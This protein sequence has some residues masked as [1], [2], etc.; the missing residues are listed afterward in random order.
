[1]PN[2]LGFIFGISQMI[3]Y[4]VYRGRKLPKIIE[5]GRNNVVEISTI[6]TNAA[7]LLN[8]A[9]LKEILPDVQIITISNGNTEDVQEKLAKEKNICGAVLYQHQNVIEV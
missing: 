1:L 4:A 7:T 9:K 6:N 8:V 2:I 3:L 5:D